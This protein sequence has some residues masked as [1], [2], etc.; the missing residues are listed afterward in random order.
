M[1]KSS[2]TTILF[3]IISVSSATIVMIVFSINR[4]KVTNTFLM[5]RDEG[6]AEIDLESS[7]CLYW[8]LIGD[9][10]CD[11]EANTEECQFDYGDCCDGQ[12]DF[13]LCS[14]SGGNR[15]ACLRF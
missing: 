12:N 2:K 6:P 1:K 13:S 14:E 7:G 9:Q 3:S 11:D 4:K 15:F 5:S 10:I 8:G